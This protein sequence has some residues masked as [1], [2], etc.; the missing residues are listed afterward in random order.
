MTEPIYYTIKDIS[1]RLRVSERHVRRLIARGD[2]VASKFRRTIRI[3]VTDLETYER[4]CR[5][6][7]SPAKADR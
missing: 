4:L 5:A 2:L 3:S 1:E 6:P 7:I